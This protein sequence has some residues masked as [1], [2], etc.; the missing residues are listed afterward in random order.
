MRITVVSV[1]GKQPDWVRSGFDA[2]ARRL[3]GSVA[4]ALTEVPL[5]RRAGNA[6]ADKRLEKEGK[7]M[8]AAIPTGSWVV[9]L[10][11]T[12]KGYTSVALARRLEQWM[13]LCQPLAM[14]IGGPDG[15]AGPCRERANELWS[16]SP[17]T[18]P[19]GLARVVLAESIYRAWSL[20]E[21]HP[22]H[23]A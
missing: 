17:L 2:Y 1:S 18:L 12:G 19:H 10:D 5:P 3:G 11:E 14:L 15:L 21:G 23:R 7:G 13:G 6:T 20:L 8:L 9:A 4:L 22:Y 16:L